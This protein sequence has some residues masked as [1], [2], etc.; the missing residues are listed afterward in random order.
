MMNFLY[1]TKLVN[2]GGGGEVKVGGGGFFEAKPFVL[3]QH[4]NRSFVSSE[5][6]AFPVT[7]QLENVPQPL[8]KGYSN[9]C[10]LLFLVYRG[11]KKTTGTSLFER[12]IFKI[13]RDSL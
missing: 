12:T 11:K 1:F 6:S 7:S 13:F 10:R 3:I 5:Q 9:S 4:F 8:N 2:L